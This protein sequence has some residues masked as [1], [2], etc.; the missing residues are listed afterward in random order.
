MPFRAIFLWKRKRKGYSS[1]WFILIN[2][3]LYF[4]K[5]QMSYYQIVYLVVLWISIYIM[6][7][8][9]KN[10]TDG[11]L[12]KKEKIVI[13]VL[14]LLNPIIAWAIFYYWWRKKLPI[15]GKKANKIS[16]I[17]IWIWI[18]VIIG[19]FWYMMLRVYNVSKDIVNNP[20]VVI[21]EY[22]KEL[23]KIQTMKNI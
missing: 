21:Q 2:M 23:K 14:C 8:W 5:T 3:F 1:N 18:L 7:N 10:K 19:Y 22:Q 20:A 9:K 17:T 6:M 12:S 15:K 13:Y 4:Y 11:L 16:F